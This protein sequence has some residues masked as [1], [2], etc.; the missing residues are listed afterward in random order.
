MRCLRDSQLK[1]II[2]NACSPVEEL[3]WTEHLGECSACQEKL[4]HLSGADDSLVDRWQNSKRANEFAPLSQQAKL[5]LYQLSQVSAHTQDG[6]TSTSRPSM[7]NNPASAALISH[8]ITPSDDPQTPGRFDN[9]LFLKVLGQGGMAIVVQAIE[10]VLERIV[11]IKI[12]LPHL[13]SDPTA[14]AR[15]LSEAK[16]IAKIE[17][18]NVLGIHRV[19]EHRET[20]YLV[21]PCVNGMTVAELIQKHGPVSADRVVDIAIQ[22]C[23]ALDAAHSAGIIHRDIKPGN[24]LIDAE[25]GSVKVSDFGLAQAVTTPSLTQTGFIA[26]TPQ[27]MSPEQAEGKTVDVRTDVYSLGVVMYAM[28]AGE[29][30][31]R[32]EHPMSVVH[33]VIHSPPTQLDDVAGLSAKPP[34][35]LT[36]LVADVI[37]KDRNAR[38]PSAMELRRCLVQ[39]TA[40]TTPEKS[41]I[42]RRL[43][44]STPLF[45]SPRQLIAIGG[46]LVALVTVWFGVHIV[47]DY[48]NAAED[49]PIGSAGP[50]TSPDRSPPASLIAMHHRD[51]SIASYQSLDAAFSAMTSGAVMTLN[52]NRSYL[53]SVDVLKHFDRQ[54]F[55]IEIRAGQGGRAELQIDIGQTWRIGKASRLK[56]VGIDVRR[57]TGESDTALSS[58]PL[59][60]VESGKLELQACHI[61]QRGMTI[62]AYQ[63]ELLAIEKSIVVA[64]NSTA[65]EL[66]LSPSSSA[67]ITGSF[68][69]GRQCLLIRSPNGTGGGVQLRNSTF[70]GDRLLEL[71]PEMNRTLRVEPLRI[72]ARGNAFQHQYLNVVDGPNI[73]GIAERE[74]R[75]HELLQKQVQWRGDFNLFA[76]S[77]AYCALTLSGGKTIPGRDGILRL[78]QWRGFCSA[79][80]DSSA[81]AAT[82]VLKT[83]VAPSDLNSSNFSISDFA[84]ENNRSG[85]HFGAVVTE[86]GPVALS[87]FATE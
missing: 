14:R 44:D 82:T 17:H 20:P 4:D 80:G 39:Q 15:F 41:D 6:V 83:T 54:P 60:D 73:G 62:A 72:D 86:I 23:D 37:A 11:A 84:L 85:G 76:I 46:L 64:F 57:V 2:A 49:N 68:V 77:R 18:A 70:Y 38:P 47:A 81:E 53:M 35:W 43:A 66:Q 61:Q 78:K 79:E 69:G 40:Y 48:F 50:T 71:E 59:F 45:G 3:Q 33:Q 52:T 63:P 8:L 75:A 27:F 5:A 56:L 34:A 29:P 67:K 42:G 25:T 26:G 19:A 51:G 28:L 65:L 1:Q 10:P 31:F 21:M 30:P 9:Y 12:L 87:E 55:D 22:I 74:R 32:G 13:A 36:A 58:A 7:S 16:A 24:L